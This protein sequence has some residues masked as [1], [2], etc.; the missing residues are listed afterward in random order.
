VPR[1]GVEISEN[2]LI[3]Y[4]QSKLARYKSPRRIV[5]APDLPRNA[6]GKVQKMDLRK[7]VCV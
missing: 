5:F 3:E 1:A 4:C 7:G 6:M 2:E